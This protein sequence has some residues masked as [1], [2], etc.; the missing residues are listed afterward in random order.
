MIR[1]LNLNLE[2]GENN[3]ESK[4]KRGCSSSCS[5]ILDALMEEINEKIIFY[6]YSRKKSNENREFAPIPKSRIRVD[7]YIPSRNIIIEV[8]GSM[9]HGHGGYGEGKIY[10]QRF[11]DLFKKTESR[12][13]EISKY[14][15]TILYIW[16][17]EIDGD[18]DLWS[19]LI[20][21]DGRLATRGITGSIRADGKWEKVS[22]A[23]CREQFLYGKNFEKYIYEIKEDFK[24]L[25]PVKEGDIYRWIDDR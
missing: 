3:I 25:L 5:K 6:N 12:F 21:F 1:T 11:Y 8:L 16:L 2:T 10:G 7:G 9:Y 4:F 13:N 20:A 19:Q 17:N 22:R 24:V 15:Y 23:G 18:R 14:G